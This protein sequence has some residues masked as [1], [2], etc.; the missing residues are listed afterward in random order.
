MVAPKK[1]E[2]GIRR[3]AQRLCQRQGLLSSLAVCA[4]VGVTTTFTTTLL[5]SAADV[6]P[7]IFVVALLLLLLLL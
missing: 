7:P 6:L 1:K 5:G 2:S 4:L 3:T